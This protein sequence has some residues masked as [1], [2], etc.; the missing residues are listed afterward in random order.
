MS[1]RPKTIELSQKGLFLSYC[2]HRPPL[3]Q[4]CLYWLQADILSA[5]KLGPVANLVVKKKKK[6]ELKVSGHGQKK[7]KELF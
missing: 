5:R 6:A 1:I 7:L 2:S 4:R 3:I